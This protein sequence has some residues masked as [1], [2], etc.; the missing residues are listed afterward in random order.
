MSGLSE[1]QINENIRRAAS[2]MTPNLAEAIWEMP[3]EKAESDAWFLDE[4]DGKKK[5]AY[6]HI[7]RWTSLVAA[8]AAIVFIG[9]F[10]LYR[11]PDATVY[12]DVNPAVTISVNRLERVIDAAAE[13]EDGRIILDN[14]DL[15]NTDI[16]VAVNALLGSMVRHGYLNEAQNI[17]LVSVDGKNEARAEALKQKI[18]EDANETLRMLIGSGVILGQTVDP[19]DEAEAIAEKYGITPGKAAL[20]LRLLADQPAWD[21]N[22]LAGM[23]VS[24][25]IRYCARAGVDISGYLGG[26]GE[27]LGNLEDPE[28]LIE[29]RNDVRPYENESLPEESGIGEDDDDPDEPE[30]DDDSDEPEID[31]D[32]DE[33][34][35]DEGDD[36]EDDDTDEDDDIEEDED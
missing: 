26:D 5:S 24:D 22:T 36:E 27:V 35:I 28:D 30:I 9:W 4:A 25:L 19:D 11:I 7:M 2:A 10:G 18:S 16:N 31:D 8:C 20:L 29:N 15:I 12:L 34:E 17:L 3:V 32:S 33:P 21:M 13:N 6:A 1:K 23:P 14:M